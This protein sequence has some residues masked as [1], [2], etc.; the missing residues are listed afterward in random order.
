MKNLSIKI[1]TIIKER[2]HDFFVFTPSRKFYNQININ[3]KR[4]AQI[5]RGEIDPT[6][7]E[8]T[9]IA[10]FFNVKINELI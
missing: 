4:W 7:A 2:E 9:A 1:N 10:E 5:R 8:L 3:Q 6:L